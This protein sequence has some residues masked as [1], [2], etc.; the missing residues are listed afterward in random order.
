MFLMADDIGQTLRIWRN[1]VR[2]TQDQV[3][4]KLGIDRS[5]YAQW[6]RNKGTPSPEFQQQLAGLGVFGLPAVA[7]DKSLA[8]AGFSTDLLGLLIDTIYDCSR[9]DDVRARAR[10]ELYRALSIPDSQN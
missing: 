10:R 7:E 4:S 5:R 1:K 6:E 3:A 2:L 9:D 8:A